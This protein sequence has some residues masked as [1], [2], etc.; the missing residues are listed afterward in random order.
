MSSLRTGRPGPHFRLRPQPS[1]GSCRLPLPPPRRRGRGLLAR[2]LGLASRFAPSACLQG[3]AWRAKLQTLRR[4]HAPLTSVLLV[5]YASPTPL[6]FG[7]FDPVWGERRACLGCIP[8]SG[9]G[10]HWSTVARVTGLL[11]WCHLADRSLTTV[12]S[13]PSGLSVRGEGPLD[14]GPVARPGWR[15]TSLGC[16]TAPF[17]VGVCVHTYLHTP[18]HAHRQ[19]GR[20]WAPAHPGSKA[21]SGVCPLVYAFT[22]ALRSL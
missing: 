12:A 7:W 17:Q 18:T 16:P 5:A 15:W 9:S 21:K 6:G 19:A 1:L 4:Q 2:S 20:L 11:S 13:F 3:P 22:P 14:R 10:A 8:A